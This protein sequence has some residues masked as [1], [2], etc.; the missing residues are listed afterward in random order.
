MATDLFD[1]NYI[2]DVRLDDD[3]V[4][5]KDL[6]NGNRELWAR[7]DDAPA[8]FHVI[9]DDQPYEFCSSMGD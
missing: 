8:S 4:I 6:D 3:T 1:N 2:L 5:L 7:Q 9:I